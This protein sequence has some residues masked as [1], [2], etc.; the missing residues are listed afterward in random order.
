MGV[1][2]KTRKFAAV[3]RAVSPKAGQ[4]KKKFFLTGYGPQVKRMIGK[5]DAR[6]KQNRAKAEI[7][8]K[9]KE[10]AA[11]PEIIREVLEPPPTP[12]LSGL[13]FP[14]TGF[15]DVRLLS[16]D[17]RCHPPCSLPQMKLS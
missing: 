9:E 5:R 17:P 2:K 14:E 16:V 1:A 13:S 3:S 12:L 8:Q 10:A 4:Q 7:T 11:A 6:L 15:T